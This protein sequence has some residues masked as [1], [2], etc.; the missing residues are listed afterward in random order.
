MCRW[1]HL[2]AFFGEKSGDWG[3]RYNITNDFS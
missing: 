1:Y 2:G 3:E